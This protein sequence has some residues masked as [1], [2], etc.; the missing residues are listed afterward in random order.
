LLA[1]FEGALASQDP[2]AIAEA[3]ALVSA[4][5]DAIEGERYL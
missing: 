2:R 1:Y 4:K 5:L 3:M